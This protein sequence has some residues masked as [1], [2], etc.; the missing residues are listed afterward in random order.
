MG[1]PGFFRCLFCGDRLD[2]VEGRPML[3]TYAE[4]VEKLELATA[5]ISRI[6][7][8]WYKIDSI[9]AA[10]RE[11]WNKVGIDELEKIQAK[12][13]PEWGMLTAQWIAAHDD[14]YKISKQWPRAMKEYLHAQQTWREA[15]LVEQ[16]KGS[17]I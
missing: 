9:C 5:E 14:W 1:S 12:G 11:A 6:D 10:L 8:E 13:K 7:D 17:V 16:D 3:K 15:A 2:G 4:A